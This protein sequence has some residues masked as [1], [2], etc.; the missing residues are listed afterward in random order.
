MAVLLQI[1]FLILCYAGW[2]IWRGYKSQNNESA[3]FERF[4]SKGFIIL[5]S[6]M[7]PDSIS[8]TML[9]ID[10]TKKQIG[11][12]YYVSGKVVTQIFNAKDVVSCEILEDKDTIIKTSNGNMMTRAI[13]GG[14]VSGGVGA[15][16]GGVTAEKTTKQ[17]VNNITL[18][19]LTTNVDDPVKDFVFYNGKTK[20]DT[21]IYQ[22]AIGQATEWYGIIR[23]IM[24]ADVRS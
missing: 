13:I 8:K 3:I 17:I 11:F 5:K 20:K 16:I 15:V 7:I 21:S 18:R 1:G 2:H 4:K 19:I 24:V 22:N 9:A 6:I 12:G 10:K 23:A 14:V